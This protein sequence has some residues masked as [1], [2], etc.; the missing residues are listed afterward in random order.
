MQSFK[1][2]VLLVEDEDLARKTLSFYLNTIFD[3]VVLAK[4]GEEGLNLVKDNFQNNEDFDLVITD[5]NIA[6]FKWY[7]DD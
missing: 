3:E 5:L 1:T 7:A 2:K 6:K 4:D